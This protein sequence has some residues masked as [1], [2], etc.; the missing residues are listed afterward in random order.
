MTYTDCN[1]IEIKVGDILKWD[2]GRGPDYG[3]SIH[4][5]SEVGGVLSAVMRIGYPAWS[6]LDGEEPIALKHFASYFST[7]CK[8]AEI[9]GNVN[10]SPEVMSVEKAWELWPDESPAAPSARANQ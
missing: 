6:V 5:V 8:C 1:G 4:E 7:E 2:E 10:D 9:I 3:R